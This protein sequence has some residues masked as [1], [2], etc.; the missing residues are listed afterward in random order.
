MEA[1]QVGWA[2]G[3]DAPPDDAAAEA[4]PLDGGPAEAGPPAGPFP[5]NQA[6]AE[7]D[8]SPAAVAHLK[9]LLWDK[10]ESHSSGW[11]VMKALLHNM[12]AAN[13]LPYLEILR[14]VVPLPIP[15]TQLPDRRTMQRLL[16]HVETV[17]TRHS[18]RQSR[19]EAADLS[20]ED[21]C[22]IRLHQLTAR[23][24]P[25]ARRMFEDTHLELDFD[26]DAGV[27][28]FV[29]RCSGECRRELLRL[30]SP[31]EHAIVNER[32]N[33]GHFLTPDDF[34]V[35]CLGA[36]EDLESDCT[37]R[38]ESLRNDHARYFYMVA[39]PVLGGCVLVPQPMPGTWAHWAAAG[40]VCLTGSCALL[41]VGVSSLFRVRDRYR[42]PDTLRRVLLAA[43]DFGISVAIMLLT[44]AVVRL[45]PWS[46]PSRQS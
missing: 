27:H 43:F 20:L 41:C 40:L 45:L 7:P 8:F 19:L 1:G 32:Y 13:P 39:F 35:H 42:N 4:G 17:H 46:R 22:R 28:Q 5:F 24:E 29:A 12:E 44:V 2:A 18:L 21:A 33:S 26:T 3:R 15:E 25:V 6:E 9:Q 11:T 34:F 38:H 16:R 23:V 14:P 10:V 36:G 31:V 30:V 37:P